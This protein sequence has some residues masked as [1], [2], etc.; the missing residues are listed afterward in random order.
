[1]WSPRALRRLLNPSEGPAFEPLIS[2]EARV[3]VP[4]R[5]RILFG[6]SPFPGPC[7][8]REKEEKKEKD[9][10]S[11]D[12]AYLFRRDHYGEGEASLPSPARG[13]AFPATELMRRGV[14]FAGRPLRVRELFEEWLFR[15][16]FLNSAAGPG[17]TLNWSRLDLY[18]LGGGSGDGS[19]LRFLPPS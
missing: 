6:V 15:F 10:K 18:I 5:G 1:V 7:C 13:A 3:L 16:V 19:L 4:S 9:T 17:G 2:R 12:A 11:N 8:K 14:R